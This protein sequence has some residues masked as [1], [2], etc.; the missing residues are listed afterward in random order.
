MAPQFKPG[1]E[2]LDNEKGEDCNP[3]NSFIELGD[4]EF[5]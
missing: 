1:D 2:C 3:Q 4:M 5:F